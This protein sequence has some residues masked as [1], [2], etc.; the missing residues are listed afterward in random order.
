M[1]AQSIIE[2]EQ[3]NVLGVCGRAPFV[4]ERGRGSTLY[5][6]NGNAYLDC[7]AG[8]AVNALGYDD[9]G[10]NQALAEAARSGVLHVSN[11][12]HTA[13]H[14]DL[15]WRLVENSFADRV[16][17]CNSGSEA[18]ETALK[19]ARKWGRKEGDGTKTTIAAFSGSFHGRT[20][21]ALSVT[22]KTT[23]RE[24]FAPLMPDVAFAPFNDLATIL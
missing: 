22:A 7:V 10:V 18:N 1:D 5:D 6:S 9:A 11:L 19:F 20:I 15:A 13:P 23:Y 21:G 3:E 16:F 17:F 24:P 2:M 12:Y 8:I 4:L 14:V